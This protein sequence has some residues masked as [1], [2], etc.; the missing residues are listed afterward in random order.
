MATGEPAVGTTIFTSGV[1]QKVRQLSALFQF[2][3]VRKLGCRLNHALANGDGPLAP[4]S[5]RL[6]I[7]ET[8]KMDS[9]LLRMCA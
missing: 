4:I 5:I 8:V 2:V 1:N 6:N 3:L 9:E 7:P